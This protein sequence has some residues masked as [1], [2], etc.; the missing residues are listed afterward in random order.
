MRLRLVV[1]AILPVALL[2]GAAASVASA[3][4]TTAKKAQPSK[5]APAAPE[6]GAPAKQTTHI[7]GSFGNWTLLCGKED[8]DK[9]AQERCSLVLPLIEKTSQKLIFRVILTYGPQGR[10]VLRMDGPTGLALQ[11]GVEF[12]TDSGGAY[13]MP[14]Q[15]CLPMGCKAL[16]LVQNEMRQN[17]VKSK[18][19]T[20]VVYALNGRAIQT[21]AELEGLPAGLKALDKKREALAAKP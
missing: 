18:Q 19:A 3:Q 4:T 2:W 16:L 20:I 9:A 8:G 11:R 14:F 13:R 17:L 10:L 21:V 12:S 7:S 15:T 6:T 5:N 1:F